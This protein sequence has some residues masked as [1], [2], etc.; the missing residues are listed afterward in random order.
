MLTIIRVFEN[1]FS[2]FSAILD[3]DVQEVEEYIP[4]AINDQI[5][6]HTY[7]YYA[8]GADSNSLVIGG[9][10]KEHFLAIVNGWNQAICDAAVRAVDKWRTGG[11]MVGE[12]EFSLS[13][14][15]RALEEA[16]D[17]F[18]PTGTHCVIGTYDNLHTMLSEDELADM[19]ANP[20]HYA[21]ID[22]TF[23]YNS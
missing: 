15:R 7:D 13:E 1:E 5:I 11:N 4:S 8:A 9:E 10:D 6:D 23:K 19:N 12:H 17:I 2:D 16:D 3:K 20:H 22:V 21:I 18:T 14:A